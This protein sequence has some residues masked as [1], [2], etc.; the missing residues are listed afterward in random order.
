MSRCIGNDRDSCIYDVVL[1]KFIWPRITE[2]Q[3]YLVEL[4]KADIGF[5][6]SSSR[7]KSIIRIQLSQ[8]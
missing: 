7:A 2:G 6:I 1:G 3:Y 8:L 4:H 5:I